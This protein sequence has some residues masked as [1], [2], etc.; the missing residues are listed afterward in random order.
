MC[1]LQIFIYSFFLFSN[2]F[3]LITFP[4]VSSVSRRLHLPF[5][6]L[7]TSAVY[8]PVCL[9]VCLSTFLSACLSVCLSVY[10][11]V[12]L[13]I[14]IFFKLDSTCAIDVHELTCWLTIFA[15]VASLFDTILALSIEKYP[16]TA[17]VIC[18]TVHLTSLSLTCHHRL[19]S[20]QS[21]KSHT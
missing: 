12:W 15:T 21:S 19:L 4:W 9:S 10:I 6:G 14:Y 5:N 3:S 2:P 18:P 8:L 1:H 13:P 7:S 20:Y 16:S 11:S 17:F